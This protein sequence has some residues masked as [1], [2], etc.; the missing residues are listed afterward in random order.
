MSFDRIK[1]SGPDTREVRP[2]WTPPLPHTKLVKFHP[3]PALK[4]SMD[5]LHIWPSVN[6][7]LSRPIKNMFQTTPE[8]AILCLLQLLLK[9]FYLWRVACPSQTLARSVILR[10]SSF[11]VLQKEPHPSQLHNLRR[12]SLANRDYL[13]YIIFHREDDLDL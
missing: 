10:S 9:S 11:T 6:G 5:R 7:D 3:V 2:V 1:F 8:T 4:A 13:R 12:P